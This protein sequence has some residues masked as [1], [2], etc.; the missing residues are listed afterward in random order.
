MW[1]K[2]SVNVAVDVTE[3]AIQQHARLIVVESIIMVL[4]SS[5]AAE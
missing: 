4:T 1:T 3:A 2:R 5:I